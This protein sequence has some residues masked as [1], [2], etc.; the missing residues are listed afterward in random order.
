VAHAPGEGYVDRYSELAKVL[1]GA[2]GGEPI[3]EVSPELLFALVAEN[4]RPEHHAALGQRDFSSLLLTQ[5]GDATHF[6][7]IEAIN[8]AGSGL[9]V[10]ITA[11][12]IVSPANTTGYLEILDGTATGGAQ[13]SGVLLDTR[14]TGKT[15][16]QFASAKPDLAIGAQQQIDVISLGAGATITQDVFFRTPVVLFPGHRLAVEANTVNITINAIFFGYER[17]ITPGEERTR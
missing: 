6:A 14:H 2:R 15:A 17:P 9:V 12:R 11:I 16:V 4:D 7:K 10:V 5:I 8:P 3:K 13:V 1:T